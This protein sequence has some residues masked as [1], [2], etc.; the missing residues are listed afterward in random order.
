MQK[1][2]VGDQEEEEE[3]KETDGDGEEWIPYWKQCVS[4]WCQ[5]RKKQVYI[6][7]DLFSEL[8]ASKGR[9]KWTA[10]MIWQT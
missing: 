3:E 8:A 10:R 9:P 6:S 5:D 1:R 2:K 7:P 4:K